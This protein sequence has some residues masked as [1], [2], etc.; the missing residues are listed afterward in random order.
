MGK[1]RGA[2]RVLVRKPELKRPLEDPGLYG[3]IILNC[4]LKQVGLGFDWVGLAR[5]R[6]KWRT[7]VKALTIIRVPKKV[8]NFLTSLETLTFSRRTM[9][10][11]VTY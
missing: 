2:Y 9:F 3:T 6:D 10:R 8:T 11:G 5:D 1:R 4:I 7:L